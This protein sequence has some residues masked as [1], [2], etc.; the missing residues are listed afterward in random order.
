MKVID[1]LNSQFMLYPYLEEIAEG[2]CQYL[3]NNNIIVNYYCIAANQLYGAHY[4]VTSSTIKN[5]EIGY[6]QIIIKKSLCEHNQIIV[7]SLGAMTIH[8]ENICLDIG[9]L[10]MDINTH[11]VQY[12]IEIDNINIFRQI[13]SLQ[14]YVYDPMYYTGWV[15]FEE[16]Y[17]KDTLEE[18]YTNMK[19]IINESTKNYLKLFL[20]LKNLVIYCEHAIYLR[21][22]MFP[23]NLKK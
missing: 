15:N 8:Y 9:E 23:A 17:N 11:S 14:Y 4:I 6:R 13:N 18:T 5:K 19:I 21:K 20:N 16:N 22:N 2:I 12:G 10:V 1:C 7:K 3:D